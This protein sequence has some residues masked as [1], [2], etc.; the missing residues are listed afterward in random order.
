MVTI[1][2]SETSAAEQ[3]IVL[4]DFAMKLFTKIIEKLICLSLRDWDMRGKY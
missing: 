2:N 3:S 4:V 1:A